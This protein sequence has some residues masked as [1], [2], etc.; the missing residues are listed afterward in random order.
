MATDAPSSERAIAAAAV[1]R[2]IS[3]SLLRRRSPA[4]CRSGATPRGACPCDACVAPF[5]ERTECS[6][7]G[8]NVGSDSCKMPERPIQLL[9]TVEL[10]SSKNREFHLRGLLTWLTT[11]TTKT[12]STL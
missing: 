11:A 1:K 4:H 9:F 5:V 6:L 12:Q 10:R 8:V 7:V 2:F 3:V